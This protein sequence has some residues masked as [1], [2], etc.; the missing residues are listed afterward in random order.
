MTAHTATSST[1]P[2]WSRVVGHVERS[3]VSQVG[4]GGGVPVSNAV[5]HGEIPGLPVDD[6]GPGD[7]AE[8]EEDGDDEAGDDGLVGPGGHTNL[9]NLAR[10]ETAGRV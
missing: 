8:E 3:V 2:V 4:G 6:G 5:L 7:G 1:L 9:V 10:D